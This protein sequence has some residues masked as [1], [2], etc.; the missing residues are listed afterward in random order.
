MS[1]AVGGPS[2]FECGRL[3]QAFGRTNTVYVLTYFLFTYYMQ[4]Q[5]VSPGRHSDHV[6]LGMRFSS[7]LQ[8]LRPKT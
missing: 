8:R 3:S 1:L 5:I 4:T 2:F 7:K 6:M